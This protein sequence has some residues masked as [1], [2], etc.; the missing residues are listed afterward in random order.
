M[1]TDLRF[2]S[3]L[4]GVNL[5]RLSTA[6]TRRRAVLLARLSLIGGDIERVIDIVVT[7]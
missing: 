7:G 5:T 2:S 1:Q 6:K 3:F 4:V